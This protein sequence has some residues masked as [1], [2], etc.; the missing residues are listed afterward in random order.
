MCTNGFGPK[1]HFSTILEEEPA[2][3]AERNILKEELAAG[4]KR[5]IS[6]EKP[7]AGAERKILEKEPPSGRPPPVKVPAEKN[8]PCKTCIRIFAELRCYPPDANFLF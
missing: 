1:K 6:K 5:I 4:A 3:G 7:A 8:S 2:A